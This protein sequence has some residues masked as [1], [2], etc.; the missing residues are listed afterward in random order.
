MKRMIV[1]CIAALAAGLC[2]YLV[3]RLLRQT[4]IRA[5]TASIQAVPAS[6]I[7]A[8]FLFTAGSFIATAFQEIL[9][10][11]YS[12]AGVSDWRAALTSVGAL[13]LGHSLGLALLSSGAIRYRMY[14]RH[15]ASLLSIGEIIAFCAV[16]VALGFSTIASM[17]FLLAPDTLAGLLDLSTG[18]LR[19]AG[20]LA[21]LVPVAYLV[22]CLIW[23]ADIRFGK[24][25][26]RLP[27]I[28]IAAGQIAAAS[29]NIVCISA[30]LYFSLANFVD[31][32]LWASMV[33]RI[34]SDMAAVI[35]HVPGGW[36]VLE[37]IA[38]ET[39]GQEAMAGIL[40]FR[41][42]Y[43]LVPLAVGALIFAAD[44]LIARRQ[45]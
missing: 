16:S 1:W 10:A 30:V 3:F 34:G 31:I 28:G 21:L 26:F 7:V 9:A 24:H 11:R 20:A 13:G 43:Y 12:G 5:I 32:D 17:A 19:G 25:R 14:R 15:G 37:Y 41:G 45:G 38:V 22:S 42:V 36:G 29:L 35:A 39:T 4:D 2:A 23:K 33:L 44:E 6:V 40:V 18:W 27:A 8:C